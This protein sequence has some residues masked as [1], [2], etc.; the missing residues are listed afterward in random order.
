MHLKSGSNISKHLFRP[1]MHSGVDLIY[2]SSVQ[3]ES[4]LMSGSIHC[5]E[6]PFQSYVIQLLLSFWGDIGE[7]CAIE[8]D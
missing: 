7:P 2:M 3:D 1:K 4:L 6:T 8:E 5:L